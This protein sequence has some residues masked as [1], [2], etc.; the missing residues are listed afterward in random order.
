M[1]R[2]AAESCEQTVQTVLPERLLDYDGT[3]GGL[4]D[5]NR[6]EHVVGRGP[7][8]G[9][10][11]HEIDVCGAALMH[12]AIDIHGRANVEAFFFRDAGD[13]RQRACVGIDDEDS[14]LNIHV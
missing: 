1:P 8:A 13:R 9:V 6:A 3:D 10:D 12:G 11:H 14:W 4:E 7:A 5:T 2:L